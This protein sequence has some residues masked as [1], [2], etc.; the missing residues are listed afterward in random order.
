MPAHAP[1]L[2]AARTS[3]R[4]VPRPPITTP[5]HRMSDATRR[6]F[7]LGVG[8]AA[9]VGTLLLVAYLFPLRVTA[10]EDASAPPPE[11]LSHSVF[12]T[13]N[14]PTPENRDALVAACREH[15]SGHEGVAFFAAGRRDVALARDVNDTDFDVAL[16]L[17]FRSRE[18]HD[19][20]QDHPRHLKFIE[21][22]KASWKTVR[23]FDAD[24]GPG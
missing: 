11:M 5:F 13:L 24:V 20:Y 8:L 2:P 3:R 16:L 4:P 14:D 21:E 7:V 23:V 1:V 15:L 17:V 9:V 18:A 12:F 22:N 19:R 10:G 6:A